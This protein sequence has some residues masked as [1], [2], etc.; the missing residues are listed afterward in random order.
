M[1]HIPA[2]PP[3]GPS[4]GRTLKDHQR[5][6]KAFFEE[7]E[8]PFRP[9]CNAWPRPGRYER[10]SRFVNWPSASV[11]RCLSPEG[12]FEALDAGAQ[13]QRK[14]QVTKHAEVFQRSSSNVEG[15][16][17]YLSLRNHQLRGLDHPRKWVY[18]TAIHNFFLTR[19]DHRGG[20]VFRAKTSVD[21]YRHFDFRGDTTGAPQSATASY[22]VDQRVPGWPMR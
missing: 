11:L 2:F 12:V 5:W 13:N 3:G 20:T 8:S 7:G 9:L 15:C 19:R 1:F 21:V 4:S 22:G 10:A 18:L 17:G 14:A 6:P 16:N